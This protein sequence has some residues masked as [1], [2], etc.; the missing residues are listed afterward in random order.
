MTLLPRFP[1]EHREPSIR[2]VH[3]VPR[4]LACLLVSSPSSL[5]SVGPGGDQG[6]EYDLAISPK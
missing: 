3:I 5:D 6:T 1:C 2:V 4:T